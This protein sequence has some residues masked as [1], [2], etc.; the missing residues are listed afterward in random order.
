[1]PALRNAKSTA[2]VTVS[3]ASGSE[4]S[5]PVVMIERQH[6]G[7][8]LLE[9]ADDGGADAR[10]RCRSRARYG[11]RTTLPDVLSVL[12]Q[13]MGVGS[14]G[15]GILG[16]DHRLDRAGAPELQQL[17]RSRG[18][19]VGTPRHQPAEVEALDADVPADEQRRVELPPPAAG[20][21]DADDASPAAPGC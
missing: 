3:H 9:Q 6:C 12:D 14:L 10:T 4:T 13:P 18:H 7:A 16:A 11:T 21:A 15:E 19:D 5:K 2:A 8:F 1:M 17:A 20:V